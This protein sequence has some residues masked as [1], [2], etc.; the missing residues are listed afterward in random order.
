M[1]TVCVQAVCEEIKENG[2][3]DKRKAGWSEDRNKM[4]T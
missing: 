1:Y 4:R 3:W 2:E